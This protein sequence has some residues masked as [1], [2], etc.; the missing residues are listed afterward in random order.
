ML[1]CRE[2]EKES[3][4]KRER[5]RERERERDRER[6]RERERERETGWERERERERERETET[7]TETE[8]DRER[9]RE[10]E[11]DRERERERERE[12]GE[13]EKKREREG[14]GGREGG[15]GKMCVK[16]FLLSVVNTLCDRR[17]V[18]LPSPLPSLPRAHPFFLSLS[19]KFFPC[20]LFILS[21]LAFRSLV[22]AVRSDIRQKGV[23]STK[24]HG[25]LNRVT[26][27]FSF[28]V[29]V[30]WIW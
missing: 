28:F 27:K 30:F 22:L 23:V 6:K 21:D 4:R 19:L 3:E 15:G 9:E 20:Y 25:K 29:I 16:I 8:T 10:R 1:C 26:W 12:R 5:E 14:E 17:G 13:G 24:E 7:E 18:L 11:R 2:R